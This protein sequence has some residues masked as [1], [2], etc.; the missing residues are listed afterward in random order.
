MSGMEPRASFFVTFGIGGIAVAVAVLAYVLFCYAYTSFRARVIGASV[1]AVW[2]TA[3]DSLARAGF[4][5]DVDSK[6]PH[7]LLAVIAIVVGAL[8]L[9]LSRVGTRIASSVPLW[10][11]VALM[12]FR[13]P[14]ELVMHTAA[15]EGVMPT[16]MSY[17]G[18]NFD[19]V[20]GALAIPVAIGWAKQAIPRWVVLAWNTLGLCTV[21][22][23]MTI[24]IA[25][26]P[27]LHAF[28][29]QSKDVNSWVLYA[30]FVWLPAVLVLT[31]LTTHIIVFRA[32]RSKPG[33]AR[34]R[35][36]ATIEV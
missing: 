31:A 4:F 17:S 27:A 20:T 1:V 30:P 24:G 2:L 13:L 16:R 29:E 14:L 3:F 36:P 6:P 12:A 25:S 8:A 23:V 9:S 35:P 22:I 5:A 15:G 21:T 11:L 26:S 28:G 7:F 34:S 32:L 18:A 33:M 19:I 10:M